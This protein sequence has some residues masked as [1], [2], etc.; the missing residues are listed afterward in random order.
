MPLRRPNVVVRVR[1]LAESGGHADQGKAHPKRLASWDDG[2]IVLEETMGV[3]S[4]CGTGIRNQSFT[5]AKDVLGTTAKQPQVYDAVA[6]KLVRSVCC[7]GFNGLLFAY[8]QTGTGKTHTIFGPQPSW[9][10][11]RHEDCG[12]LPRAVSDIFEQ[13]RGSVKTISYTLTASALEFYMT[14][15]LDLLDDGKPCVIGTDHKPLG[16]ASMP[17]ESEEACLRFMKRVREK[18]HA[19]STRMNAASDGHEGSSRSHCSVILTLRQLT[20]SSASVLTTELHVMDMAGAERPK[21]NDYESGAHS[22][23]LAVIESEK[24]GEASIASQ[25]MI[26]NYEL[27][28]LRTAVVQ[29]SE[30]HQKGLPLLNARSLGTALAMAVGS[31]AFIEYT[32][33]CFDGSALVS[34]LPPIS[35]RS[36]GPVGFSS[37]C[38]PSPTIDVLLWPFLI[39]SSPLHPS[40][41]FYILL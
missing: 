40:T 2:T 20:R 32:K 23:M 28:Q 1:P 18:R 27:S 4:G 38:P 7:D 14:G 11:M 12:I 8:G 26:I 21:S 41:S 22:G 24:R 17:I 15:C 31:S 35:L 5:F 29:A 19:R 3:N 16:L 37:P 6:A 30:S 9:G 10:S 33:G 39:L 34:N 36:P 13:M 25:G